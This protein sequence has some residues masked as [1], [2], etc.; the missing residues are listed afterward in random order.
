MKK[1]ILLFSG[2]LDSLLSYFILKNAGYEVL[3]V[4]FY[5][6]FLSIK[7]LSNYKKQVEKNYGI[8]LIVKDI[9]DE[10][11][12]IFFN[13][14]FGFG[15]NLNPC[16]DCKILF[17]KKAKELL[18]KYNY[19]LIATGEVPGQRPFSQQKSFMNLIE[20]QAGVKGYLIRP[21]A[22]DSTELNIEIDKKNFFNIS[23]RNRK[24]QLELAKKFNIN[25]I[26]SPGGGCL[27]TDPGYCEK[28]K[29]LFH[30]FDK[31]LLKPIDFEII[32]FGRV[33]LEG[34]IVFIVG[35]NHKENIKIMEL[36]KNLNNEDSFI[37]RKV[38]ILDNNIPS[39]VIII[40]FHKNKIEYLNLI[41]K[42]VRTFKNFIKKEFHEM[43]EKNLIL[44]N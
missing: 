34:N 23:G 2:G 26:P 11:L 29:K 28:I 24:I 1:I 20:K 10:Y 4:Q 40:L 44:L 37:E 5:M 3:P 17:L 15:K 42:I 30:A 31:K 6:P 21:L 7:D 16:V 13:P 9:S 43:I 36:C 39:P 27:L 38:A 25:P 22:I 12:N 18:N 32:K 14:K 35:R 41:N 33:V 19:D 8:K